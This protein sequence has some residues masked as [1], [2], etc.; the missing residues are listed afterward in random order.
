MQDAAFRANPYP[1]YKTLRQYSPIVYR[2]AHNDWWIS[3]YADIAALLADRR[4]GHLDEGGTDVE[5]AKPLPTDSQPTGSSPLD[6]LK[7]DSQKLT[8]LWINVKK[9]PTHTRLRSLFQPAFSKHSVTSLEGRI[10]AIASE[11]IDSIKPKKT[12]DVIRDFAMPCTARMIS[13]VLSIPTT[14]RLALMKWSRDLSLSIDMDTDATRYQRGQLA[15]I[16]FASYFRKHLVNIASQPAQQTDPTN[17]MAT[18]VKAQK[19]G[20]ISEDELLANCIL[21]YITGQS[22]T[23]HIIGNGLLALLRH[24]EQL[25]KLQ[26]EPELIH[27]AINECFRYDTSAQFISRTVLSDVQIADKLLVRG[28]RVHLLLGSGNHDPE[29]FTNPEQF[30]SCRSPNRHLSFGHGLH[31]CLGARLAQLVAKTALLGLIQEF[32]NIR[33]SHPPPEWEA[34]YLIHG[35]KTLNVTLS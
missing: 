28:Q 9:P 13:E 30:D 1:S 25:R 12:I 29:Q 19:D 7:A 20:L 2:P 4:I 10:E 5:R 8:Q 27:T 33:L 32:P 23:Q 35:L 16:G 24:P 17:M 34:S 3:R 18:L 21:L 22:T 6:Q 11:L 14:P 31:Y 26:D 15:L